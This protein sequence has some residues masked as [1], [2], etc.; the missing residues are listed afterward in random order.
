VIASVA[1]DGIGLQAPSLSLVTE[2]NTS[3]GELR[4]TATRSATQRGM[5]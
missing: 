5:I 1:Y 4:F 2:G 3:S